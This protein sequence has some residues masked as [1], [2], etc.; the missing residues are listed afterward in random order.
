M[1][2]YRVCWKEQLIGDLFIKDDLYK[3]V[4]NIEGIHKIEDQA[5]LLREVVEL[6][7]WGEPISFFQQM[8]ENCERFEGRGIYYQNNNYSM[9]E[10]TE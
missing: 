7:D 1:K 3:Y 5:F 2:H 10:V 9:K 6:R 8:I 4:P